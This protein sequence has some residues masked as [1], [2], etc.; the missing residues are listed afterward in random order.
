MRFRAKGERR[1][2]EKA[3]HPASWGEKGNSSKAATAPCCFRRPTNPGSSLCAV[4]M[5]FNHVER[6]G[7]P[8]ACTIVEKA[9][10]S[11]VPG[12]KTTSMM[13]SREFGKIDARIATPIRISHTHRT[14]AKSRAANLW[15]F[16]TLSCRRRL[17][18]LGAVF[19]YGEMNQP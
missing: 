9:R 14:P 1:F 7:L 10:A 15:V 13:P 8:P 2:C 12:S 18:S 3:K 17:K 5:K 19:L 16:F 11:G 4:Q 6:T